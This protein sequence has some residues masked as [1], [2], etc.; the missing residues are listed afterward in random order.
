MFIKMES[1]IMTKQ[2]SQPNIKKAT[3]KK[4]TPFLANLKSRRKYSFTKCT[5]ATTKNDR[6]T[7]LIC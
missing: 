6:P 3:S 1:T 7:L 5:K 4:S 2:H